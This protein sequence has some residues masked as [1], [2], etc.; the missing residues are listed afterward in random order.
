MAFC[1]KCGTELNS[2][3]KCPKCG[4]IETQTI[5]S[6]N[7]KETV[8]EV[9]YTNN[10]PSNDD[11][12]FWWSVLGCC[13]P[14]VGL[15]LYLVWK[16]EKPKTAKAAGKGALAFVIALAIYYLFVFLFAFLTIAT[17]STGMIAASI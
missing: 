9:I 7:H 5:H 1:R 10:K 2:D 8:Q 13:I 12:S 11:G 15:V 17:V 16:D 6:D 3:N 14:I 4:Y